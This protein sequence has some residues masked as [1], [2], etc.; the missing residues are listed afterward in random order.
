M[1]VGLVRREEL[2]GTVRR[3][4]ERLIRRL[5]VST[6]LEPADIVAI[7]SLPVMLKELPAQAAI[8]REG[9][10]PGQSCLLIE[11]F[12]CRS[13]T[14][15]IGKRQILSIHMAGDIP[16][17][18]SLH[19]RVMDH[20]V[21]TLSHCSV[22]Y[23]PHEA[24]RTLTHERPLVAEALW[25]ETLIDAAV[26]R[27]WIV[28]VGRRPAANR[29]AHLIAEVG[30][31]LEAVG[32]ASADRYELPMTQIDLADALGL[33]PVHVNRVIQELRRSGMLELRKHS[34]VIRDVPALIQL[35]DFDELYLHASPAL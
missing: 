4:A 8:V 11:G 20:D 5:Q 12:A 19:L 35:G 21:T 25:R 7:E 27:E 33:S 34:V 28:N 26:F 32:L 13:K 3:P 30:K 24:L 14:T 31:R 16:D 29:T 18:Q 15:D 9:E 2:S 17:L 10:R 22:G 1:S 23:I 6:P